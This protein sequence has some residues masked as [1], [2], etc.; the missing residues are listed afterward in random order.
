MAVTAF[1]AAEMDLH[2]PEWS[3]Y[4]RAGPGWA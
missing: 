1:E 4:R 2:G 3:F